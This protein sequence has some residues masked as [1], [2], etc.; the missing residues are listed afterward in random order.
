VN[1]IAEFNFTHMALFL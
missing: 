1:A